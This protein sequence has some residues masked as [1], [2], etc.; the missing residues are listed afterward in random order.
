MLELMLS[1]TISGDVLMQIKQ[2]I[3]NGSPS[4]RWAKDCTTTTMQHHRHRDCLTSEVKSIQA[5]GSSAL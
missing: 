2:Q 3:F 1:V 4:S 5:G